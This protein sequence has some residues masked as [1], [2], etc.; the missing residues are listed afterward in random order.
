M[1]APAATE[2]ANSSATHSMKPATAAAVETSTASTAAVAS[3]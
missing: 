1:E 2:T 3:C